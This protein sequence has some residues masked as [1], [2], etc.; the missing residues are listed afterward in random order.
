[1]DPST[2]GVTLVGVGPGDPD[3]LTVAAVRAIAQAAVV[4]YPVAQAGGEGMAARIAEPWIGEGQRRLP[5]VFPMVEES[6]PRRRAWHHAAD[7]LA[8]EVGQG[9]AVALLCEGDPSLF[10]SAAYVALALAERH[11]VCPVRVVPGISAVGAAAAAA[12]TR[13]RPYPLALQREGLLIRPTPDT[14]PQLDRLLERAAA[15]DT[16]LA[17]L[18]LGGRWSWVRG[19]LEERRL[20]ATTLLASR[21]GWPDERLVPAEDV[22]ADAQPY[23]S[24]LLIRQTWPEVLPGAQPW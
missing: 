4:A 24:L 3:L 2:P 19:C 6:E 15:T 14:A 16:V 11:P 23:F 12:S 20:L 22:P 5:L 9:L 17:L 21:V 7:A 1:M 13:G 8:A 18:K 10:A